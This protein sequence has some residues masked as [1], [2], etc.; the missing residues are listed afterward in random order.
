MIKSVFIQEFFHF[1]SKTLVRNDQISF[2]SRIFYRRFSDKKTVEDKKRFLKT[3]K[4]YLIS[5]DQDSIK[6]LIISPSSCAICFFSSSFSMSD[7]RSMKDKFLVF[8][9]PSDA[10]E[11]NF[12]IPTT[13][14]KE[15][16]F[17]IIQTEKNVTAYSTPMNRSPIISKMKTATGRIAHLTGMEIVTCRAIRSPRSNKIYSVCL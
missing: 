9:V 4:S 17:F 8:F 6:S 5:T 16:P 15:T 10:P 11:N 3:L 1:Q 7:M 2:Q 13:L 12:L 14:R